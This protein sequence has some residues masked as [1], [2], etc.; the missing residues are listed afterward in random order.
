MTIHILCQEDTPETLTCSD[1]STASKDQQ[2]GGRGDGDKALDVNL[3]TASRCTAL[4][5]V[6][7]CI[8]LGSGYH[9]NS[10]TIKT[11]DGI[12]EWAYR[13]VS[14]RGKGA[15]LPGWHDI[16]GQVSKSEAHGEE[17][18]AANRVRERITGFQ[19]MYFF[20]LSRYCRFGLV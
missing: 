10:K 3:E 16:R 19:I 14:S 9:E 18:A 2:V 12:N 17:R 1:L 15:V 6:Q 13:P 7:Y 11:C 8:C 4:G 5:R 20:L